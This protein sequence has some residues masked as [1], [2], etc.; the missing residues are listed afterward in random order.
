MTVKTKPFFYAPFLKGTRLKMVKD[1]YNFHTEWKD[2]QGTKERGDLLGSCVQV[3]ER[4]RLKI[5][6]MKRKAPPGNGE[7]DLGLAR[8]E[9][10]VEQSFHEL[11]YRLASTDGYAGK[12]AES[13][14]GAPLNENL[15]DALL[16]LARIELAQISS[17]IKEKEANVTQ[18]AKM[19]LAESDEGRFFANVK[20]LQ[21][22]AERARRIANMITRPV[23]LA[24]I[25]LSIW[26]LEIINKSGLTMEK[27]S[28]SAKEAIEGR[29]LQLAGT[30]IAFVLMGL[31]YYIK[32]AAENDLK[33]T[34]SLGKIRSR[35]TEMAARKP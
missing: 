22:A 21:K 35:A 24:F 11:K 2:L 18:L 13:L 31:S 32:K 5:Q 15:K 17:A 4:E 12:A 20:K 1:F 3:I 7:F 8:R 19:L 9:P 26:S 28:E 25:G 23:A 14:E 34:E 27:L 6:S 30:V 16:S 29:N 10:L 33:I